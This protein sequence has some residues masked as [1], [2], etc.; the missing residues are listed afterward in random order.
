M[1]YDEKY[2]FLAANMDFF[3]DF[4]HTKKNITKN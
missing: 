4:H 3:F 2:L 1:L